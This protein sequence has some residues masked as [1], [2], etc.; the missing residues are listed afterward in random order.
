MASVKLK[1][2]ASRAK[3]VNSCCD[4]HSV[5]KRASK[6]EDNVSSAVMAVSGEVADT[7]IGKVFIIGLKPKK[8]LKRVLTQIEAESKIAILRMRAELVRDDNE[9]SRK[10]AT[11]RAVLH[12]RVAEF[13]RSLPETADSEAGLNA[14]NAVVEPRETENV[15][16]D[17]A[18]KSGIE[19]GGT[20]DQ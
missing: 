18:S 12:N 13:C 19:A 5:S 20:K 17:Q 8:V 7:I 11:C 6:V 14:A 2:A 1:P 16:Y 3:S 4:A 10:V 15:E 9:T